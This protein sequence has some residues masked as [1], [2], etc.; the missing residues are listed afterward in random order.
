MHVS[1]YLAVGTATLLVLG[2]AALSWFPSEVPP[3]NVRP[4]I[5]VER[6][7]AAAVAEDSNV[8]GIRVGDAPESGPI[9]A[10]DR[11]GERQDSDWKRAL[12][13]RDPYPM[14]IA[15]REARRA[16]SFAAS[17]EVLGACVQ[18][19]IA[20]GGEPSQL[21][22]KRGAHDDLLQKR[23]QAKSEIEVRCSRFSGQDAL[24]LFSPLPGDA[25]GER[26]QQALKTLGNGGSESQELSA[27]SEIFAQGMVPYSNALS[28][29]TKPK[30]WRGES[31]RDRRAEFDFA[32][33]HALRAA[34]SGVERSGDDLREL[35]DCYM[36]GMCGGSSLQAALEYFAV[37]RR[38]AIEALVRDMAASF[39]AGDLSPLL[40]RTS[41][42]GG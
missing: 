1:K 42:P 38:P 7:R 26:Y 29:F 20:I 19:L 5:A 37:D 28:R 17:H 15:L 8:R 21:S 22:P 30:T 23:L 24:P 16:G 6:P 14:V 32:V 40:Q 9:M 11:S 4:T 12:T 33:H 41:S 39:A 13:S 18:A 10:S 27:I 36:G 25:F 3:T 34:S 35:T 2:A 31:W